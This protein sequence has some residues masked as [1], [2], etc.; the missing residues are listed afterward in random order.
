MVNLINNS[1]RQV[2][3]ISVDTSLPKNQKVGNHLTIGYEVVFPFI[4]G[5][6]ENG[7]QFHWVTK[8]VAQPTG[9]LHLDHG[10]Y[11]RSPVRICSL[12]Y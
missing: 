1:N 6:T 10:H 8:S 11:R 9:R 12:G 7:T 3:K 4:Q 5:D 2:L